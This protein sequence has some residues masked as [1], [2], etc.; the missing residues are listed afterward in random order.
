MTKKPTCI[1][2]DI[3]TSAM[4]VSTFSLYQD[5]IHH[6]NILEDWYIFCVAY[7]KLGESKVHGISVTDDKKRFKKNPS[8]DYYVVKEIAKVLRDADVVIGHNS[9]AF[10]WKKLNARLIFHNLPPLPK[11]LSVDTLKEYRK[12]AKFSS[13]RLDYLGEHLGYGGKV[14]TSQGLWIRAL[15]GDPDAIDEMLKY[16]KGDVKL[17]EKIYL[18][19]LPHMTSHPHMGAMAGKER[20]DSC[21]HCGS[22]HLEKVRTRYTAAGVKKQQYQ[23]RDCNSY[24]TQKFAETP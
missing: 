14:Q 3:E 11:I 23:C 1:L 19:L 8:D 15:N 2:W 16:C 6:S 5:S 20:S 24:S 13:N 9:N 22:N 10:D 4:K 7:K 17:L 21:P 18:R 12:I